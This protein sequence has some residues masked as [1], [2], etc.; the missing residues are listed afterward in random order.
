MPSFC[1]QFGDLGAYD[2]LQEGGYQTKYEER[3]REKRR[4]KCTDPMQF[5][6]G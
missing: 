4:K 6:S 2:E 5:D 3:E 1:Y